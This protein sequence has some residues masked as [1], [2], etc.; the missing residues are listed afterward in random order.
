MKTDFNSYNILLHIIAI[1]CTFMRQTKLLEVFHK[2]EYIN[3]DSRMRY[4]LVCCIH[5]CINM[6]SFNHAMPYVQYK[7]NV[8]ELY[9]KFKFYIIKFIN[10]N[11]LFN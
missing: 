7:K 3:V 2:K 4:V 10:F 8:I 1:T 5:D 9:S 11:W 6:P